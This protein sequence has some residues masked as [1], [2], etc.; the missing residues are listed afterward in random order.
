MISA[1]VRH[2]MFFGHY[3]DCLVK[4]WQQALI[5][6]QEVISKLKVAIALWE[7]LHLD[8]KTL[9]WT[10]Q[11]VKAFSVANQRIFRATWRQV[12]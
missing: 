5:F 10:Q 6:A 2:D 11:P 3:Q 7:L 1:G 9:R 8:L 4:L 12:L